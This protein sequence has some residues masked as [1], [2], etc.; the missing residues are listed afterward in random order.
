MNTEDLTKV[1]TAHTK[2][3][4]THWA[5]QLSALTKAV[6]TTCLKPTF[7][8]GN[9]VPL[10]K[11][12]SDCNED[13]NEFLAN[14]NRTTCFYKFSEDRKA[15]ILPLYLTGNAS[16]WY[17]TKPGLSGKNFNTLA[18]ALKKQFH[19][20]SEVWLS[21]QK[22]NEQKQLATKL[23]SEFAAGIRHLGQR[24]NLPH[25]E[26]INHFI[27]GLTPGLKIFVILQGPTL[28][29][30]AK[31]HAKLKESVPEPKPVDRTDEI[32]KAL[33]HMQQMATSRENSSVAAFD[34]FE[35]THSKPSP[36]NAL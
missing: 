35:N 4:S 9:S 14:F 8:S 16:I 11:F 26:C 34:H 25:L 6:E 12:S 3:L 32:L 19:S 22:L 20:D 33:A 36:V 18:K 10:P 17:N 5:K 31:M 7:P 2:D 21:R 29:K 13:V 27:Q 28:F 15:E 1:L 30:K 23:V 24:I